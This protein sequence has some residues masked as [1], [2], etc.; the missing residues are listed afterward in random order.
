MS[1]V[2]YY[3]YGVCESRKTNMA[4]WVQMNRETFHSY[5]DK[6]E[7]RKTSITILE[8]AKRGKLSW[9]GQ[10]RIKTRRLRDVTIVNLICS[11]SKGKREQLTGEFKGE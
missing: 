8:Y 9:L 6:Y 1:F 5:F 2:N 3:Y 7:S 10:K 4:I 11:F